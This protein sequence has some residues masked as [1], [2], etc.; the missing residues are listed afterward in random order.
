[1]IQA[2]SQITNLF[3]ALKAGDVD[4]STLRTNLLNGFHAGTMEANL[5]EHLRPTA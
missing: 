1:M 5:K 2:E 4:G 3:T